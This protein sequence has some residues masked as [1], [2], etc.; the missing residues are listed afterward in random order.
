MHRYFISECWEK[1][2]Q[3]AKSK[4]ILISR[5]HNIKDKELLTSIHIYIHALKNTQM[6]EMRV[7]LY[8][9]LATSYL[10]KI[11]YHKFLQLKYC[12]ICLIYL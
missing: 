8:T 10:F 2:D 9:A 6:H 11:G 7:L 12:L 3:N 5:V 4:C 1:R